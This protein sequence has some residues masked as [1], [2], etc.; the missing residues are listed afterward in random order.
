MMLAQT[1]GRSS[2]GL[3]VGVAMICAVLV[4]YLVARAIAG[5]VRKSIK[6]RQDLAR[7]VADVATRL[8]R[9]EARLG[10]RR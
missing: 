4:L 5:A 10:E 3:V 9:I 7:S 8:E 6:A 2:G 1:V